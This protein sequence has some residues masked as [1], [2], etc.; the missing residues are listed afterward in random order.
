[1]NQMTGIAAVEP[2]PLFMFITHVREPA[3]TKAANTEKTAQYSGLRNPGS[4]VASTSTKN[5]AKHTMNLT[6]SFFV[7]FLNIY[8][9]LLYD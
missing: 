2:K 3:A 1:M 7:Q 4:C 5:T 9:F 6:A 8:L